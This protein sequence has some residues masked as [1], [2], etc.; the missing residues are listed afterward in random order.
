[1]ARQMI[2]DGKLHIPVVT[3]RRGWSQFPVCV[4]VCVPSPPTLSTSWGVSQ[5]LTLSLDGSKEECDPL[6]NPVNS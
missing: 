3:G 1:M 4:C 5:T 6:S 2:S